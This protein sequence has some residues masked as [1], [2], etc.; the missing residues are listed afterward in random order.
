MK[1]GLDQDGDWDS[2]RPGAAVHSHNSDL[3]Q[4][5][6]VN[7]DSLQKVVDEI[8]AVVHLEDKNQLHPGSVECRKN[9]NCM[10]R[11]C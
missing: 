5:L 3:G 2:V 7:T 8:D 6:A 11:P 4:V 9:G 10:N 1:G